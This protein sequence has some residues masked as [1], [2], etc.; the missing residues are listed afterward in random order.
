MLQ[1]I[2][3]RCVKANVCL[4]LENITLSTDCGVNKTHCLLRVSDTMINI[5][6]KVVP[7]LK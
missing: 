5:R 3:W 4:G 1:D 6:G 7:V 2:S